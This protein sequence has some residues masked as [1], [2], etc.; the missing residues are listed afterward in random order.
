MPSSR[1][2]SCAG[3]T[4]VLIVA[5]VSA[6]AHKVARNRVAQAEHG[7]NTPVWLVTGNR[8]LAEAVAAHVPA[9]IATLPD[10]NR[11]S[12]A[13]WAAVGEIILCEGREAR[14]AAADRIAP[15]H[16]PVQATDLAWGKARLTAC[17][18]VFLGAEATVAFGDKASGTNPVLSTSDAARYT[19]GPSV[20]KV[21]RTVTWQR[22]ELEAL[23]RLAEVTAL[24][25]P[26][27]GMEAHARTA[28][29]R[30]VHGRIRRPARCQTRSNRG[31]LL[32]HRPAGSLAMDVESVRSLRETKVYPALFGPGVRGIFHLTPEL[33]ARQFRQA[34]FD[35][36]WL[37]HG[38]F[39]FAPTADRPC[40][41]Y[42]T[43]GPSDPSADDPETD[44]ADA[45]SGAGA[46]FLFAT[47]TPGDWAIRVLS[48]ILA[49][50]LLSSAG[51]L[52]DAEPLVIGDTIPLG[53]PIDVGAGSEIRA[54]LVAAPAE[55]PS[56]FDLPSG[57]VDFLTL[58][59]VTIPEARMAG[60]HGPEA[61]VMRLTDCGFFPITDPA[62]ESTV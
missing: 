10:L 9:C 5:D 1:R 3:P 22:D 26:V 58:V 33:F 54:L 51:R 18:S 61:L 27:E 44:D 42:V 15:A 12:A 13:A 52:P 8:A 55:F 17:G 59:G 2:R 31:S 32:H 21:L 19:G 20:Q 29:L 37:H 35:P 36:R 7:P 43:S 40:W 47:T 28:N 60:D 45:M 34:E 39:E 62:R 53:A 46:E 41:L 48:A 16:L 24:I 50:D 57:R 49:F 14:A 25:S 38:V 23:P 11:T 4:D 30:I 56:G 6:D